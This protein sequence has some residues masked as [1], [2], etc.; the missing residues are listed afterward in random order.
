MAAA[1]HRKMRKLA[2]TPRVIACVHAWKDNDVDGGLLPW[3]AVWT[4]RAA[5]TARTARTGLLPSDDQNEIRLMTWQRANGA[6]LCMKTAQKG[7]AAW[8]WIN[9]LLLGLSLVE[10]FVCYCVKCY[11]CAYPSVRLPSCQSPRLRLTLSLYLSRLDCFS[12]SVYRLSLSFW[13]QPRN[14]HVMFGVY[15]DAWIQHKPNKKLPMTTKF[16]KLTDKDR[17]GLTDRGGWAD[18]YLA[19]AYVSCP[20]F[21][22]LMAAAWLGIFPRLGVVPRIGVC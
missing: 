5:R 3:T 18:V 1:W 19:N 22:H 12:Y 4:A 14:S 20:L 16:V 7:H 2:H 6:V 17:N 15:D 9:C 21:V 11:L 10:K 8:H 13:T